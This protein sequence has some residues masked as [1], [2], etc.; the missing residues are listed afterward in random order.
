MA[1]GWP[2]MHA[3]AQEDSW[4]K[5]LLFLDKNLKNTVKETVKKYSIDEN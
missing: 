2:D 3:H 1:G 5:I 4:N